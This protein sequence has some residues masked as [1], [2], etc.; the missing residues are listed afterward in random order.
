M[1]SPRI[2]LLLLTLS[3]SLSLAA[4]PDG[5]S[6]E[7]QKA[8]RTI[9]ASDR[10][11][12]T[13]VGIAGTTPEV[14]I[15]FRKMLKSPN[16]AGAFKGLLADAT[17]AGMLYALCGLYYAD[18]DYFEEAVKRFQRSSDE[19]ETLMGCIGS[20]ATVS[21]IV[22]SPSPKAVRL[23]N[24][25]QTVKEWVEETKASDMVYDIVGGGWPSMFKDSGGYRTR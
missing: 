1:N 25:K 4:P 5:L 11:C 12:G 7:E 16:A 20:R 24:R 13:S 23:K 3:C 17:M 2:I 6:Q 9:A 14:V 19:V 18:P 10:F 21:S 8:Y 22:E 15:A